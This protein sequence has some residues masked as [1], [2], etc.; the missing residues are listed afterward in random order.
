MRREVEKAPIPLKIAI[1]II[2]LFII[3]L[4][5]THLIS[6]LDDQITGTQ[7]GQQA[8]VESETQQPNEGKKP[9]SHPAKKIGGYIM[10]GEKTGYI[11]PF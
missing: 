2:M 11:I 3:F 4:A 5:L 6:F 10:P 1:A 9:Q 8:E 7:T